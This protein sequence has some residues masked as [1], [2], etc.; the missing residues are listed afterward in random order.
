[1]SP[2]RHPL[3]EE[4][5]KS[6]AVPFGSD[7]NGASSIWSRARPCHVPAS[8]PRSHRQIRG[9]CARRR[10]HCGSSRL[11]R[12]DEASAGRQ[13]RMMSG[14]WRFPPHQTGTNKEGGARVNNGVTKEVLLGLSGRLAPPGR[15]LDQRNTLSVITLPSTSTSFT[16][17]LNKAKSVDSQWKH[18]RHQLRHSQRSALLFT[19]SINATCPDPDFHISIPQ[20]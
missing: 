13:K 7:D 15:Q 3:R 16:G 10:A 20:M 2:S 6:H 4:A 9:R 14:R 17:F 12:E 19:L 18:H 11:K 1:M 8:A 5:G